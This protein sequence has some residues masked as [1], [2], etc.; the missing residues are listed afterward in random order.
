[1]EENICME[2][3]MEALNIFTE[4]NG[5]KIT[6]P[7]DKLF[8]A[9]AKMQGALDN[10]TKSSDNPYFKSKYADLAQCRQTAK[11]PM[12]DN[13][14]SISQHCTFDGQFVQ[15]VTILGHSS[16]QMMISTLMIPVAKKDAQGIGSSITY[17][18]RYALSSII[19]LTQKDD[20][21]EGAVGRTEKDAETKWEKTAKKS[22]EILRNADKLNEQESWRLTNEG[23]QVKWKDGSWVPL[24]KIELRYLE[25]MLNM[26]KFE[27]IKKT[28]QDMIAEIK[29]A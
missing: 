9:L 20:D 2:K 28:V 8:E 23:I 26:E 27:G 10:A 3:P 22:Q 25:V 29:R 15:C 1:M 4:V 14:L 18:R 16:G 5:V 21:G 17:A 7:C 13:G 24:N 11:K 19:G 6:M 12:A